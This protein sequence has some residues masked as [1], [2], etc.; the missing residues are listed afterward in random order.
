MLEL[1]EIITLARQMNTPLPGKP[2]RGTPIGKL[3][4]PGGA[5]YFCPQ[6]Q[7]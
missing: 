5:A 2:I 1:P 6:C 7:R 4:Y 3:A